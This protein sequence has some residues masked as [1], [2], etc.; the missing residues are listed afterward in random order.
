MYITHDNERWYTQITLVIDCFR[1]FTA[2]GRSSAFGFP[3]HKLQ[4]P[5]GY[6]AAVKTRSNTLIRGKTV[7]SAR[8]RSLE[9]KIR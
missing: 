1:L 9:I 6:S 8:W 5:N 3:W 7:E 4:I 2:V